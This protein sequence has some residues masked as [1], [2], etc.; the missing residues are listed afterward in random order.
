MKV[1]WIFYIIFTIV[2]LAYLSMVMGIFSTDTPGTSTES[3]ILFGILFFLAGCLLFIILPY[4]VLKFIRK[5]YLS[6][7]NNN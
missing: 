6:R 1:I 7:K 2:N 5:K 4:M 3:G